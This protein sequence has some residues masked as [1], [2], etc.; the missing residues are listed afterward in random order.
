MKFV[1]GFVIVFLVNYII[2]V[3][4]LVLSHY[5]LRKWGGEEL[6]YYHFVI[7]KIFL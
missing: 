3:R 7:V 2:T 1:L 5:D 4:R 6:H